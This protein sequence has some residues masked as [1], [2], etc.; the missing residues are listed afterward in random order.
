MG[1]LFSSCTTKSTPTD[2]S[3]NSSGNTNDPTPTPGGSPTVLG[4]GDVA[5]VAF[6][7][8][9]N[10]ASGSQDQFA[11]V[12]L[13]PINAG[14]QI[15]FTT[16]NWNGS[17][18]AGGEAQ[19]YWTAGRNYPAGSVFETFNGPLGAIPVTVYANGTAY[20]QAGNFTTDPGTTSGGFGLSKDGDNLFAV[21]GQA[22]AG[23]VPTFLAGLIFK[24]NW[25][26][27]DGNGTDGLPPTLTAGSTAITMGPYSSGYYDCSKTTNGTEAQLDTAIN[28]PL[29]WTGLGDDSNIDLNQSADVLNCTLVLQ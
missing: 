1:L 16:A 6:A 24:I 17:A 11:A 19:I 14:T 2:P 18:M 12:L 5:I 27:S 20:N 10:N 4:P 8:R 23:Q 13:K 15:T 7:A 21:Q 9:H 22:G 3:G 29:N 26:D 25:G 28:N